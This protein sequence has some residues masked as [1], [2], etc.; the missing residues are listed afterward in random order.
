MRDPGRLDSPTVV[1]DLEMLARWGISV[2]GVVAFAAS[3]ALEA[4][5]RDLDG[6][7]V[8]TLACCTAVGGGVIR[9]LLIGAVPVAALVDLWMMGL[10]VLTAVVVMLLVQTGRRLRIPLLLCDAVGLGLFTVDGALKGLSFGLHPA[11]ATLI[12]VVTGVGGGILRDVLA[13]EVPLVFRRRSPR[14]RVERLARH[15]GL[16]QWCRDVRH[17]GADLPHPDDGASL[18]LAHTERAQPGQGVAGAR[19]PCDPPVPRVRAIDSPP[20]INWEEQ[21]RGESDP[22]RRTGSL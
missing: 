1:W 15:H 16:G 20:E 6:V 9:D 13:S 8:I 14:Q 22:L 4:K 10:S 19:N 18:R 17:R 7:G 3:G 21:P 11:A 5:R 2:A 12:G